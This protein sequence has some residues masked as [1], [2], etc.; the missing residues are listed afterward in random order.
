M[1]ACLDEVLFWFAVSHV[2]LIFLTECWF[3]FFS[4][5]SQGMGGGMSNGGM[6]GGMNQGGM[7]G[8]SMG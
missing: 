1:H 8:G 5:S 2:E 3:P 4:S 7:G 6:G